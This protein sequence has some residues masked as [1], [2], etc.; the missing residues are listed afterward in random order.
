MSLSA[1]AQGQVSILQCPPRPRTARSAVH[2]RARYLHIQ[3]RT[4]ASS[5]EPRRVLDRQHRSCKEHITDV[6]WFQAATHTASLHRL[7][8]Q[9][10]VDQGADEG[11]SLNGLWFVFETCQ[12]DA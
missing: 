2:F 6:D 8:N 1:T 12:W 4:E 11:A 9:T 3:W 7:G 5:G 10:C